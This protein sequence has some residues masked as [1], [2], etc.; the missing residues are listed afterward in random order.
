MGSRT[1]GSGFELHPFSFLLP[2]LEEGEEE[3]R[4]EVTKLA[5]QKRI[6]DGKKK[7]EKEFFLA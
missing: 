7:E 2:S 3:K 4:E 1:S 6:K 5:E